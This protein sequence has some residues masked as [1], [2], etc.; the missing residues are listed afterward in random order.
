MAYKYAYDCEEREVARAKLA[1]NRN[2][3][4][5]ML[6]NFVT[7]GFYSIAFFIPLSYDLDKVAPKRDGTRT[8]NYLL[9]H[10]VACFS[11]GIVVDIWHYNIAERIEE[12]LARRKIDC[13][14]ETKDF[15]SWFILGSFILVG[16]FVYFHKLCKAMN[17]LCADYNENPVITDGSNN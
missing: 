12:A 13:D 5:L 9:A 17:L 14:F 15:W 11:F 2:M 1:T 7:L 3:W 16:P 4:K 8:M 10:I 6:L